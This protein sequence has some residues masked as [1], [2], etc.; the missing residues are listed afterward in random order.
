M[1]YRCTS[2]Y[3]YLQQPAFGMKGIDYIETCFEIS[4][5]Q[6]IVVSKQLVYGIG[7]TLF[8]SFCA[9]NV[10]RGNGISRQISL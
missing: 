10:S 5:P 9:G 7:S 1:K 6:K 2:I 4:S 8:H 3:S